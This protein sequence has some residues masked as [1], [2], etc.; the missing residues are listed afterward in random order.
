M[1]IHVE[2]LGS[3]V[4]LKLVLVWFLFSHVGFLTGCKLFILRVMLFVHI[5]F[6]P[7]T[8]CKITA[9]ISLLF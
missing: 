8:F 6:E 4:N 5:L 7:Y 9:C 1:E 3:D 2:F